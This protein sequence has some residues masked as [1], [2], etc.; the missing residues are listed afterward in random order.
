MSGVLTVS[1]F[2]SK[3]EEV[4]QERSAA[5]TSLQGILRPTFVYEKIENT[6]NF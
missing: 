1:K 2:I 4:K 5:I 3:P 6:E